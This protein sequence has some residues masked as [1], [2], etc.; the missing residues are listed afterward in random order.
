MAVAGRGE[1]SR[2]CS[3]GLVKRRLFWLLALAGVAWLYLKR[4]GRRPEPVHHVPPASDPADELR[5]KLDE[6]KDRET[7]LTHLAEPEPAD[8]LGV[9]Q[10]EPVEP[11]APVVSEELDARRRE[12]HERAR[13]AAD[14]MHDT[15]SD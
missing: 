14:E 2:H 13:A 15:S 10:P 7:P 12:I 8:V 6:T 4:G 9:T 1:K 5:R 11:S 3:I